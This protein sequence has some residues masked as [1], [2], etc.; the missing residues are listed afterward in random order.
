MMQLSCIRQPPSKLAN[1]IKSPKNNKE[2]PVRNSEV[3][4]ATSSYRLWSPQRESETD[5]GQFEPFQLFEKKPK[6]SPQE[7]SE[8][9]TARGQDGLS[10]TLR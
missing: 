1:D 7:P 2:L 9:E 8:I 6:E 4:V 3:M 5:Q 10:V